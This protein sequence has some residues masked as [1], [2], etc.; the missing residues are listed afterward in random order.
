MNVGDW[1]Q[2]TESIVEELYEGDVIE[3]AGA[4]DVGHV[5]MVNGAW[6]TVSFE[7]TGTVTDA[8]RDQLLRLC[9][10]D[11]SEVYEDRKPELMWSAP[12]MARA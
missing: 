7:R 4:R 6:I 2:A 9:N 1:V 10:H 11:A 8:H 12:G 3:H 5:L